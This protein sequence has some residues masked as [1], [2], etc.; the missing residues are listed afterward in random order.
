M[1]LISRVQ[2]NDFT[3]AYIMKII[4]TIS[5]VTICPHTIYQKIINRIPFAVY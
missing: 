1:M 3:F 5:L 4:T 2:H